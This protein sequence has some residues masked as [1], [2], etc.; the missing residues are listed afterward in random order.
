MKTQRWGWIINMISIH[1][2]VASPFKTGYISAKHGL[3]G[4]TR[5]AD[6]REFHTAPL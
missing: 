4:L 1:G 6:C 3:I 5:T 2:L